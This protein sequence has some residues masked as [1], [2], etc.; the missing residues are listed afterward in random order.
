M[1]AT[2]LKHKVTLVEKTLTQTALGQTV[3]RR[4]ISDHYAAVIPLDVETITQYMQL[5]TEVSHRILLRGTVEVDMGTHEVLYQGQ[6]YEPTV[7]ATH[8]GQV[9][10]VIAKEQ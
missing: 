8:H 3:T 5:H 1:L 6:L 10:E 4:P 7:S 2:E 9:T